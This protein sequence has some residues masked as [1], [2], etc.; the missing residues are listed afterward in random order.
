MAPD[1]PV[2]PTTNLMEFCLLTWLP[3]RRRGVRE[4]V[5]SATS[6]AVAERWLRRGASLDESK[7]GEPAHDCA[8]GHIV[9]DAGLR[10]DDRILVDGEVTGGTG[11][12]RHDDIFFEDGAARQ[13]RLAADDVVFADHASMADLAEAVDFRAALDA[14]FA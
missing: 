12:A 10:P 11:L 5:W 7:A 2:M 13:P 14:C 8:F 4:R 1:A 9:T 3:V 6:R